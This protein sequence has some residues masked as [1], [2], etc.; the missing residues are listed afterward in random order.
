[1]V[2]ALWAIRIRPISVDPVKLILRIRGLSVSSVPIIAAAPVTTS[3]TSAGTPARWASS[4]MTRAVS[5][6][7]LAGL[8]SANGAA[9]GRIG[10]RDS[11]A[12]CG[13]DSPVSHG[14][15]K[16]QQRLYLVRTS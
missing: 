5:G 15:L 6:V 11:L 8:I 2:S 14:K 12:A 4:T 1:M 13:I 9:V 3:N 10:N 7:W 16:A